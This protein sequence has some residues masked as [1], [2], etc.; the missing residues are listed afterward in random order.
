MPAHEATAR[1]LIFDNLVFNIYL[2]LLY[3]Y[4]SPLLLTGIHT[5]VQITVWKSR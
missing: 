5:N 4:S 3:F 1:E 2:T